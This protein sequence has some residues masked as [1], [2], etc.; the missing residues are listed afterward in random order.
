MNCIFSGDDVPEAIKLVGDRVRNNVLVKLLFVKV[1]EE[2][3]ELQR[4]PAVG[5]TSGECLVSGT[6]VAVPEARECSASP[7]VR[8]EHE[9]PTRVGVWSLPS[10]STTPCFFSVVFKHRQWKEL[11]RRFTI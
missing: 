2:V 5:S 6:V 3:R 9:E 10:R 1:A 4:Q 11:M 8:V 7:L